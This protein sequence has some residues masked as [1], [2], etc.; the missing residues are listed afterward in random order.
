MTERS[1]QSFSR[2]IGMQ[3]VRKERVSSLGTAILVTTENA[4]DTE[5]ASLFSWNG[6]FECEDAERTV[7]SFRIVIGN[8]SK[9]EVGVYGS[10]VFILIK[11]RSLLFASVPILGFG[12]IG[13]GFS[14][15]VLDRYR[16]LFYRYRLWLLHG[17][18]DRWKSG[19]RL[20][21]VGLIS[22]LDSWM[23]DRCWLRFFNL[24]Y[25]L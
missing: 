12:Y 4:K 7:S 16:L 24:G 20:L 2:L 21:D 3:E 13:F 8:R 18:L 10:G 5:R 19:F 1:G 15:W 17:T 6:D 9:W 25:R 11:K 22:G 23:L 14:F